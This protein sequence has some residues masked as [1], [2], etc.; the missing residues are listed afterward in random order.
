MDSWSVCSGDVGTFI[1][2][3]YGQLGVFRTRVRSTYGWAH[4]SASDYESFPL[5]SFECR[6]DE[7]IDVWTFIAPL[8]LLAILLAIA[9]TFWFFGPARRRAKR[10]KRGLCPTCGYDLRA[11]PDRCPE[12]G[13]VV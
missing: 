5:F 2:T 8:W 1:Q 6:H 3:A 13:T 7:L 10:A 12:C 4:N 11:T 9:P